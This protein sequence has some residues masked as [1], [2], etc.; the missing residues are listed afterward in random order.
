M[1]L[2]RNLETRFVNLVETFSLTYQYVITYTDEFLLIKPWNAPPF[3]FKRE[4]VEYYQ[5]IYN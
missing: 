1:Y 3:T 4:E 2:R 5:Q